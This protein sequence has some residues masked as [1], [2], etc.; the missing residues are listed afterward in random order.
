[1]GAPAHES[2]VLTWACCTAAEPLVRNPPFGFG[3]ASRQ[4][5]VRSMS[6]EKKERRERRT[7]A[8]A[9]TR[10]EGGRQAGREAGR[11]AGRDIWAPCGCPTGRYRYRAST[12]FRAGCFSAVLWSSLWRRAL[13]WHD[14]AV[15]VAALV[16]PVPSIHPHQ[17]LVL[18]KPSTAEHSSYFLCMCLS[19]ILLERHG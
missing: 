17:T 14:E 18:I 13:P 2:W 9:H 6:G 7:H 16:L 5:G 8:Y 12:S 10:K 19:F 1:M 11:R 3:P 15:S 4:I